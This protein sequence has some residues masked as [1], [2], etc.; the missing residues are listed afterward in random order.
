[1]E[2]FNRIKDGN[3]R[4]LLEEAEVEGFGRSIIR[5]CIIYIL[6][7]IFK[8][9]CMA[10]IESGEATTRRTVTFKGEVTKEIIKGGCNKV[11]Y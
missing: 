3:G 2:N 6:S 10:L 9:I 4:M 7:N 1:M 11:I 8:S 5:I